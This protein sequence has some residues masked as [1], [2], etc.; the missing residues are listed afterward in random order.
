MFSSVST[1]RKGT[2]CKKAAGINK[3]GTG[4]MKK[5]YISHS[6]EKSPLEKK[7]KK[8]H[9]WASLGPHF[10]QKNIYYF[11]TD[12]AKPFDCVDHNKLWKIFKEM[13]PGHL[14]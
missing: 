4:H 5:F 9:L 3:S 8:N 6:L 10:L 13:A 14:T 1:R 7:E 12:Y 11:F 2:A